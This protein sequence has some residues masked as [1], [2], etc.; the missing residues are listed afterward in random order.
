M[1]TYPDRMLTHVR[2]EFLMMHEFLEKL[3]LTEHALAAREHAHAPYSG[4]QVGAA[5]EAEDGRIFTGCN[6]ENASYSLT[7]CAERN[8]LF[9]AVAAGVRRFR[10]IAIVG[11]KSE[12]EA[13]NVP[14]LPCGA[15]LQVLAEFCPP[16]FPVL[17]TD[18]VHLLGELLP[19]QFTFSP[20]DDKMC[21]RD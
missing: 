4:F 8:A 15:C 20:S 14:C 7:I 19:A 13:K 3:T 9:S 10:K 1:R 17:L 16:A 5:L 2:E 6:V 11:G 12:E 21:R 18:G